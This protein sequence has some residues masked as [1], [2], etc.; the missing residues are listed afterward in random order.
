MAPY[1]RILN[2]TFFATLVVAPSV[3]VAD[4][5]SAEEWIGWR[6][7]DVEERM[8]LVEKVYK[9]IRSTR[10][11]YNLPNKTRTKL[12]IYSPDPQVSLPLQHKKRKKKKTSRLKFPRENPEKIH[13][14]C[15]HTDRRALQIW[16]SNSNLPIFK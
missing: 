16:P 15:R 13:A 8:K 4:Y 1:L 14:R 6:S 3:C 9:E 11:T 2:L 12:V 5:P 10:S 7:A